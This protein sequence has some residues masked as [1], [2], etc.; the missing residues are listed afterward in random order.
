MM[1]VTKF[2]GPRWN[3]QRSDERKADIAAAKAERG[4]GNN[5]AALRDRVDRIERILNLYAR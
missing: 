5:V 1:K 3:Q 4:T 2:A